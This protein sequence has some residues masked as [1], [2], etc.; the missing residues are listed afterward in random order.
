M[1]VLLTDGRNS[2]ARS[3]GSAPIEPE[4]AAG[5][6]RALGVTLHTIAIGKPGG[7]IRTPEPL[8]GL[9]VPAEVEGPDLAGL[10]RLARIGGGRAF[11]ATDARALGRVFQT[12]DSLERSP[13][14]GRVWTRYHEEF[15]PWAG[16]ALV[17][18]ILDRLVSCGRLRRLP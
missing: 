8:T 12:I 14:R 17:C 16:L 3:T 1:L 5:L 7:V 15:A 18:L 6:A 10:E 4:A 9:D 2:P 11:V 13:I